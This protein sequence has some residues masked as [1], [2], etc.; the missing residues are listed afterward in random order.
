[1]LSHSADSQ[2][3]HSLV[4]DQP[5]KHRLSIKNALINNNS[6]FCGGY[7]MRTLK[8]FTL[9]EIAATLGIVGT[10]SLIS[11]EEGDFEMTQV[12]ARALGNEI[13]AYNSAVSRYLAH[14][15]NDDSVVGSV[16]TGSSWLKGSGCSGSAV[17]EFL[18]C[19]SFPSGESISYG[20]T[21]VTE[22]SKT[23]EGSLEARTKW[24]T[25]LGD[26]GK[27]E[28]MAMGLAALVASGNVI[29]Q[30]GDVSAAYQYPT[31]FCPE[32]SGFSPS[33][34]AAC[35]GDIN[36][37]ISYASINA[38]LDN[39]L[40]VDHGNTMRHVVEFSDSPS[41]Q[42]DID[43]IDDGSASGSW[44]GSGM[45]QIIN[46]ARIYN[47]GLGDDSLVLGKKGGKNI[48]T[49][50]FL[51]SKSL[52]EDSVIV[53]GNAAVMNDLYVKLDAYFN[54]DINVLGA[55]DITGDVKVGGDV[56]VG[57]GKAVIKN[58]GVIQASKFIDNS[59]GNLIDPNDGGFG[60]DPTNY[61]KLNHLTVVDKLLISKIGVP[62]GSC[63]TNGLL[64]RT[65]SGQ[66]MSCVGK[67]WTMP[68]GGPSNEYAFFR[69]TTCPTGWIPANGTN[70]TLDMRGEFIRGWDNGRG[71][72]SGRSLGSL[73][74]HAIQSH[75]HTGTTNVAGQHTHQQ[76][77]SRHK[78]SSGSLNYVGR[79][80]HPS[81]TQA[82]SAAGAH[83]HSFTTNNTG[84]TETRPR[85]RALLVCVRQ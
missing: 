13:F 49:D 47:R 85:N 25:L 6:I 82:T 60:L 62:G 63:T 67:V 42:G 15:A 23:P 39:W 35:D 75:R 41:D 24:E 31:I 52:L 11:A 73:Q 77:A 56:I 66:M 44:G 51:D 61:S 26:G 46:V 22:I 28:T 55:A 70:G 20:L 81:A 36:S 4:V 17:S 84:G 3:A 30:L 65:S 7:K 68:G 69:S 76:T 58:N 83:S 72:D 10:L 33:I 40:R 45:R 43:D 32:T 74:G 2:H 34:S 29:S 79:E 8:G 9:V 21:P 19:E 5:F 14:H 54:Q 57:E 1:M 71:I 50:E 78:T 12:K 16:F 27:P 59:D 18:S 53:D 38:H 37:I 64:G 48:Y 80:N